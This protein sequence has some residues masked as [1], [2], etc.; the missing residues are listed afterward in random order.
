M[1]SYVEPSYERDTTYIEDRITADGGAVAGRAG[2]LPARR[3]PG[4]PVG[5]PGDHR[6]AAARSR[7]R[8]SRW[9]CAGPRTT[10]GRGPSTSTR[11]E[12]DPVLQVPRIQDAYLAPV[13]RTTPRA[14][15]CPASSTCPRAG[16]HQRLPADD[17]RPVAEWAAFHR[18]GAPDLYPEAQ[19]AE[20]DAVMAGLHR[21]QQRRLPV[22]LRRHPGGL[23]ERVRPPLRRAG[24]ALGSA[25]R[26]RYLMGDS[27]TEADVRLFTTL[28]R[29]DAVYHGH[30]KCNRQKLSEM[31]VL[32]AYARDLFQ[33]PGFGDTTDF[34]QIKRHYYV[35][36]ARHQPHRR[37]AGRPDPR[38]VGRAPRSRGARWPPVRGRAPR[39]ARCAQGEPL[40]PHTTP[41]SRCSDRQ[42]S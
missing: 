23:R 25:C 14:S 22:R 15:P 38:A 37:R 11:A 27:I 42:Q 8:S 41:P 20:M 30:F 28:A 33:T 10:S 12:V 2:P 35:V 24:L 26:Q 5:Q 40:R 18:E 34:H 17:P 4:V 36:H 31:P 7:G 9:G 29:F 19:R 6:A 3:R 21:G 39:P 1:P 13:P 32:W 16:R